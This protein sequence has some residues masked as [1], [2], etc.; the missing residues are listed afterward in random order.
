MTYGWFPL[1]GVIRG[2]RQ[3][4]R[5]RQLLQYSQIIYTERERKK[6]KE[7]VV[8]AF[9]TPLNSIGHLLWIAL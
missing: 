3:R 2:S 8:K 9:N 4:S 1:A 5:S 6:E 7:E